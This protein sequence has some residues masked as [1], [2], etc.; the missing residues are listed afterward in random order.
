MQVNCLPHA[1]AI[2]LPRKHPVALL[3]PEA[4]RVPQ[5]SWMFYVRNKFPA[6]TGNRGV[7]Q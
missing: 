4:D 6:S 1:K 5:T 2:Y 7:P 3:A